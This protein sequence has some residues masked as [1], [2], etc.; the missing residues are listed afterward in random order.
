M[1]RRELEPFWLLEL[2][3][4]DLKAEQAQW[5][6]PGVTVETF[7]DEVIARARELVTQSCGS[8]GAA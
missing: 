3:I 5:Y 8:D 7:N 2:C 1:T 6:C 4:D